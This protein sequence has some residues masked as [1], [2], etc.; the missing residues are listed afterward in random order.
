ML[1]FFINFLEFLKTKICWFCLLLSIQL[2]SYAS[3]GDS[4]LNGLRIEGKVNYGFIFPHHSLIEYLLDGNI[5]GGEVLLSTGSINRHLWEELYRNPRYG[6]GYN[7]TNYNNEDVLGKAH[8]IF[9][10]CEIPFFRP[11]HNFL[12]NYQIDFGLAYNTK[13]FD[14]HKNPM[15]QAIS[16]RVNAFVG[17]DANMVFRINTSNF[18]K[19]GLDMTH[20]SN[21]K[22]RS[23][24]LGI[25][26]VMLSAAWAYSILP[27]HVPLHEIPVVL[28]RRHIVEALFNQGLKRDDMLNEKLYHVSSVVCDYFYAYS[29]KYAVG[30]GM[31]FF[32]DGSLAP[33]KEHEEKIPAQKSDDYQCGAHMGFMVRYGNYSVILN[34][35]HYIVAPYHKYS[36]VYNRFG[37][38]YAINGRYMLNFTVKAHY[39]IADYVEWG[40]GYRFNTKG[41]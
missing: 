17:F 39:A 35:G 11:K 25:N 38:R 20:Y 7:F 5:Y 36:A 2:F 21:G 40:I 3:I 30:G 16:S 10:F 18:L 4:L 34:I 6:I 23:P 29:L 41:K 26:T 8:A 9:G 15:N 32:Y 12:V 1:T 27:E 28:N 19:L 33:T 13:V 37:M 24:N 14:I 31:D 22:M